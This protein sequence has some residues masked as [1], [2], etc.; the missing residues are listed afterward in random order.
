[1]AIHRMMVKSGQKPT[2]EQ[3]ARIARAAKKPIVYDDES[4]KLTEEQYAMFAEMSARRRAQKKK[5]VVSLRLSADT[6]KKAKMLG[7]GYT[8][9][10]SRLLD[11]AINN[12]EMVKKCL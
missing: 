6:I 5:Q 2:S 3:E 1:M 9:V 12:P 7:R 4:P 8:G 11:L 10:L